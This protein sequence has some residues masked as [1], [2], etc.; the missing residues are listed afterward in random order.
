M[1]KLLAYPLMLLILVLC[2]CAPADGTLRDG[3]YTVKVTLSGG[4]G[5]ATIASPA[6]MT[7]GDGQV[8]A[9]IVWSSPYYEY[10]RLDGMTYDPINSNGNSTFSIPVTLDEEIAVTAETIAMS[11]PHEIDYTLYFDS[12]TLRPLDEKFLP[13][14]IMVGSAAIL[15]L[16][17]WA[18]FLKHKR[19]RKAN[20]VE[21]A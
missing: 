17:A 21:E 8:T 18:G 5:R 10:M 13:I 4:S 19:R 1:K 2:S 14:P 3:Q 20:R 9:V 11:T 16:I 6:E 7:I 12:S 15:L